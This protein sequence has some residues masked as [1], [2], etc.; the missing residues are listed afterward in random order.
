MPYWMWGAIV[1]AAGGGVGALLGWLLERAGLKVG[2][3]LSVIG[4]AAGLGLMQTPAFRNMIEQLSV[5]NEQIEA[6]IVGVAPEVFDYLRVSFPDDYQAFMHGSVEAVRSGTK[7]GEVAVRS[8][9]IM[10]AIRQK[11]AASVRLAPDAELANLMSVTIAFYE[12]LLRDDPAACAQVAISG[13]ASMAGTA[14]AERYG[15]AMMPQALALFQAARAGIDTPTVRR[16]PT[17]SDWGMVGE[18]MVAAGASN[19]YLQAI[20]EPNA[21]NPDTCPALVMFLKAMNEAA[22]EEGRIVRAAYLAELAAT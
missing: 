22:T 15:L 1:G 8:T 7:K 13:P 2:R 9:Q 17:E 19:G 11:H 3:W 18:A 20:G 5:S 4:V 12:M 16:A 21:S 14:L 10:Q 6:A